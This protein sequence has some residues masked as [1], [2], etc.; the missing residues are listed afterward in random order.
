MTDVVVWIWMVCGGIFGDSGGQECKG[1]S[2]PLTMKGEQKMSIG[3]LYLFLAM[4]PLVPHTLTMPSGSGG[5]LP[6]GV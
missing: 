5:E 2:K 6:V 1:R 4:A 3:K